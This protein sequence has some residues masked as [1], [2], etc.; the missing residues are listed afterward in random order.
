MM[1]VVPVKTKTPTARKIISAIIEFNQNN[2]NG[3][4]YAARQLDAYC[5]SSFDVI[6]TWYCGAAIVA[7]R[8]SFAYYLVMI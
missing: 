8:F 2:K 3:R 6:T 1:S 5:L 4:I 7:G